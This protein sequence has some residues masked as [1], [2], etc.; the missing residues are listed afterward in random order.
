MKRCVIQGLMVCQWQ[1]I[2][3]AGIRAY[4]KKG[5]SELNDLFKTLHIGGGGGGLK[6]VQ[7]KRVH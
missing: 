7:G 2:D 4:V 1:V 6:H 3:L 5:I